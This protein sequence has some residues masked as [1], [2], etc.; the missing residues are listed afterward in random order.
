MLAD[1]ILELA[2]VGSKRLRRNSGVFPARPSRSAGGSPS[3]KAGPVLPDA[4]QRGGLPRSSMMPRVRACDRAASRRARPT[5]SARVVPE[6]STNSQ[7]PPRGARGP[8]IATRRR[9]TTSTMR[10]SMPF[11]GGGVVAKYLHAL[12]DPPQRCRR[13]PRPPAPG[14]QARS[15]RRNVASVTTPKV[16]SDPPGPGSGRSRS[17][18]GGAGADSRRSGARTGRTRCEGLQG[19]CDQAFSAATP[20][21]KPCA[22]CASSPAAD[23]ERVSGPGDQVEDRGR[24]RPYDRSRARGIRRRRCRSSRRSCSGCAWRGPGRTG[25]HGRGTR[26]R[27]PAR[28][29]AAPGRGAQRDRTPGPG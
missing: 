29:L 8:L 12:H 20:P 9:R 14:Q 27:L 10:E 15:T 13:S 16:P 19:A 1:Q 6:S 18:A 26:C 22:S 11:A 3:G 23:R 2:Q 24:C 25:A 28:L 21:S 4:P 5:I 7:A 17:L